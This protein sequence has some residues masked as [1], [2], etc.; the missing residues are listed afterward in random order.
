MKVEILNLNGEVQ[1]SIEL[2]EKVFDAQKSLGSLYMKFNTE[3]AN[4]HP[5]TVMK[6]NRGMVKGSGRKLYRQK[7]TGR[8]RVGSIRSPIRRG[9]GRAFGGQVKNYKLDL[10]KKIKYKA[11]FTLLSIK[12]KNNILKF[13][14]DFKVETPKTKD[15]IKK[16]E[17]FVDFKNNEKAT[18]I[19]YYDDE[20][21]KK[22]VKNI[23]FL[24]ILNVKRLKLTNLINAKK[25]F[26]T[27]SAVEYLNQLDKNLVG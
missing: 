24:K 12:L 14:E 23:K 2:N 20:N 26:I 18:F 22:A 3:I 25:I 11:L 17:K 15:L 21:L 10:P 4:I 16:L 8:A 13:I 19:V 9:G 7:H 5:G 1:D 27:K 6:K